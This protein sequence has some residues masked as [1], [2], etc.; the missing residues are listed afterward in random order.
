MTKQ[1]M[2][3][4]VMDD[5]RWFNINKA[6][7]FEERTYFN[8]QNHIS[9]ATGSQWDHEA[10]YRTVSGRWVLHRSSQKIQGY[11]GSWSEI[12]NDGA[13]RWLAAN[14]YEPHEACSDQY[15]ALEI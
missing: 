11:S 3:R 1:N 10:L 13:A 2:K 15:A 8:G 5:G 7:E 14:G 12:D 9:M 4:Q 6:I